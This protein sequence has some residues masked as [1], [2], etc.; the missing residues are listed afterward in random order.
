VF[1]IFSAKMQKIGKP[2]KVIIIAIMRKLL[3]I[4]FGIIKNKNQF[5]PNLYLD[6]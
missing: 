3:H 6:S 4:I 1:K 5:N 2:T